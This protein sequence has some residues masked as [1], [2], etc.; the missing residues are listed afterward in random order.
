MM[1][2]GIKAVIDTSAIFRLRMEWYSP[3]VFPSLN[4]EV[5]LAAQRT[6]LV[7]V[8]RVIEELNT[9]ASTRSPI[10]I[11]GEAPTCEQ[12][13]KWAS[14]ELRLID[15]VV[16]HQTIAEIAKLTV[17]IASK[18]QSWTDGEPADPMLIAAAQILGC[19]VISAET[20][21]IEDRS[22]PKP[23]SGS[24]EIWN[25]SG[26]FSSWI[27]IPDICLIRDV[28]HYDLLSYFRSQGWSF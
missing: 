28:Q 8:D 17:D 11:A 2:T 18:H 23:I 16:P 12:T 14:G 7:T 20:P 10:G 3:D 5:E 27:R 24:G 22:A 21:R 25:Q 26:R 1:F 15:D 9:K 19:V 13:V 4:R 6:E